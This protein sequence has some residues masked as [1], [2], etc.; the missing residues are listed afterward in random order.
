MFTGVA[1]RSSSMLGIC[2]LV[3]LVMI[4]FK[5]AE[6]S[7]VPSLSGNIIVREF[8]RNHF[9]TRGKNVSSDQKLAV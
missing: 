7:A 9:L 8:C 5:G 4:L 3:V 2:C 1:T 6:L